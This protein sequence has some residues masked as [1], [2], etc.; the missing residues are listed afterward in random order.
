MTQTTYYE[1]NK[2][3][4]TDLVNPLVD[5]N[6]NWDKLDND[7]HEFNEKHYSFAAGVDEN[8][9]AYAA[10]GGNLNMNLAPRFRLTKEQY[11][12]ILYKE[13]AIKEEVERIKNI[14]IGANKKTQEFLEKVGSA[15][16]KT[17]TTLAEII[18]RPELSYETVAELD[19]ERKPLRA[20][21]IEQVNINVKYDGYIQR[22]LKQ[23]EQFKKTESRRIPED[24]NY[25]EVFTDLMEKYT[26][27]YELVQVKTTK[28]Q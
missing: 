27:H 21:I 5:T 13:E 6:P 12:D 4:G 20:D 11:D 16:L 26:S 25:T 2:P 22:Q 8:G 9:V 24:L 19:P 28:K 1:F 17:G 3:E 14:K 7:L 18:C 10:I 23:V 15:S